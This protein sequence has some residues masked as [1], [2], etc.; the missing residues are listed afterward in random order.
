MGE[1]RGIEMDNSDLGSGNYSVRT[2]FYCLVSE[3]DV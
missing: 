3:E 1:G 2:D